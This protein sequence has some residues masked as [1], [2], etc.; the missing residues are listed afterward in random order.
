MLFGRESLFLAEF[1][2]WTMLTSL[3]VH[4]RCP[5]TKLAGPRA[6]MLTQT[7]FQ[8][9]WRG[10]RVKVQCRTCRD[11]LGD[12]LDFVLRHWSKHHFPI[13][14][15]FSFVTTS[16]EKIPLLCIPITH[17]CTH[18]SKWVNW[19]KCVHSD[20]WRPTCRNPLTADNCEH[21]KIV[22][23]TGNGC[24]KLLINLGRI[25]QP[26]QSTLGLT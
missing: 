19:S 14:M 11:I 12:G 16:F 7:R 9:F 6:Q 10:D 18:V 25:L 22:G 3:S 20:I 8:A 17:F 23:N 15:L 4:Q 1:L 13:C 24:R 5:R 21:E 2:W 26:D